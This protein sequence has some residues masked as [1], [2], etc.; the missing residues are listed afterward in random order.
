[1]DAKD[2]FTRIVEQDYCIGCGACALTCK[3]ITVGLQD[4]GQYQAQWTAENEKNIST[5]FEDAAFVCP[6]SGQGP[7]EDKLSE[8][9]FHDE[10]EKNHQIGGYNRLYAGHVAEGEFRQRGASGGVITWL[11]TEL[12]R[13]D[14][15][16][17]IIHV[18]AADV[19]TAG[20]HFQYSVSRSAEEVV[21]GAKSRYYPVEISQVMGEVRRQPGRYVF[22]GLP[23]FV[24][25]VRRLC[26]LDNVLSE[27]IVYCVGLVCGHLKSK[28]YADCFAWQAGIPPGQLKEVDFRV[29]I[30]DRA[31]YDYGV[32]LRSADVEAVKPAR[33]FWGSNWGW[34]FFRYNACDYCDDVFAET[35][36]VAVGDAWLPE[37]MAQSEGNSVVVVRNLEL[38]KLFEAARE[39]GR[40][41]MDEVSAGLMAHSQAG[42][43]RDR[44]E[45]LAYRLYLKD[46]AGEWRPAKRVQPSDRLPR[47]RKKIY[48]CRL[49]LRA[50][51]FS[52][53][54][55]A[56]A[57]GNFEAFKRRTQPA[58]CR[59]E[60][61]YHPFRERVVGRLK[62]FFIKLLRR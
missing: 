50:L 11:L 43:L 29:K 58:V 21:R 24:K 14:M 23:C 51:S 6:F 7:N 41:K 59:F 12:L 1:M 61:C 2:E 33:G 32:L 3:R 22:V 53:W 44:R 40:L 8:L 13:C 47:V 31:P 57:Q 48:R 62:H 49:E 10:C 19:E 15:A 46:K 34:N 35:A 55:E 27:R 9:L 39:A 17:A 16:D 37:Y 56:V 28:T 36:D 4:S 52:A 5:E 25:A 60:K 30:K 42:G 54:N 18:R 20:V 45:G 26:L 38:S